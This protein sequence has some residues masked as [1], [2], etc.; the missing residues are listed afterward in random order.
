MYLH[1]DAGTGLTAGVTPGAGR[2][3]SNSQCALHGTGS[4]FSTSGNNLTLNVYLT[5][6][7]TFTGQKNGYLKA[8]GKTASSAFMQEGAWTP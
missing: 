6:S 2:T 3:V 5:F 8:V 4:S 7:P 1:D